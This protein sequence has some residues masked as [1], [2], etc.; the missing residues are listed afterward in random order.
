MNLYLSAPYLHDGRAAT[1]E[2]IWTIYG[3]DEMHGELNDLTKM[4]LNYL[5]DYLKSIRDPE[6]EVQDRKNNRLFGII[7]RK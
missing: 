4:E 3:Q 6:Y 5:I 1:L 2:E 7:G